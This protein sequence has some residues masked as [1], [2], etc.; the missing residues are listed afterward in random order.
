MNVKHPLGKLR[1][2]FDKK[3]SQKLKDWL[4]AEPAAEG[5]DGSA[6]AAV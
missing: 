1:Y 3:N 2:G 6:A 4:A 5:A